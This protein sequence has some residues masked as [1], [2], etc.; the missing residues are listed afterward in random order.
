MMKPL[1]IVIVEDDDDSRTALQ[2]LLELL[3]YEVS[4]AADGVS[5][6]E[7]ILAVRPDVALVD[8]GLPGLNGYQI[9]AQVRHFPELACTRLIALTGWGPETAEKALAAGFDRQATKP[10]DFDELDS[11]LH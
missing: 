11:L 1:R 3:G 4:T 8:V 6:R 10:L 7:L 9:A 2:E 5:G